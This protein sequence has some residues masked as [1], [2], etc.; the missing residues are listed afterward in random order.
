MENDLEAG[1]R[2]RCTFQPLMMGKILWVEHRI[3]LPNNL[4]N[5][6]V[7]V[8]IPGDESNTN[9]TYVFKAW[10]LEKITGVGKKYHKKLEVV[11]AIRWTGENYESIKAFTGNTFIFWH[12]HTEAI[13]I[14]VQGHNL[15]V[16]KGDWIIRGSEGL[17]PKV[18]LCK[19][20]IF[21]QLYEEEK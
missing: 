6:D 14:E 15:Q 20:D 7:G 13:S 2:V 9:E 5:R 12:P 21:E 10:Q 8:R 18:Y 19:A 17:G 4:F 3:P 1:N 16:S 11:D